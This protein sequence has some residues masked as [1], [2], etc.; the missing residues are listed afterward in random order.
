MIAVVTPAQARTFADAGFEL[1]EGKDAA[2]G[3]TYDCRSFVCR[4]PTADPEELVRE[5]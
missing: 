2:S 4:L 5:R 3:L 1:F